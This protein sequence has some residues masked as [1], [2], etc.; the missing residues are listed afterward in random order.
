MIAENLDQNSLADAFRRFPAEA[1]RVRRDNDYRDDGKRHGKEEEEVE[2]VKEV[3]EQSGL[4]IDDFSDDDDE[5]EE[6]DDV[7]DGEGGDDALDKSSD[8]MCDDEEECGGG[9]ASRDVKDPDVAHLGESGEFRC[10]D[11]S[12][13]HEPSP[14]SSKLRAFLKERTAHS[15]YLRLFGSS[16]SPI[17]I[18]I[19]LRLSR[20]GRARSEPQD[21]PRRSVLLRDQREDNIRHHDDTAQEAGG[22]VSQVRAHGRR[23]LRL[24]CGEGGELRPLGGGGGDCGFVGLEAPLQEGV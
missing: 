24:S 11:M 13:P 8:G 10:D 6:E 20:H 23:V 3:E 16:S 7:G 14:P 1:D 17:Y 21:L 18:V 19:R 2:E 4:D 22:Q 5:E 9:K 15:T 12:V